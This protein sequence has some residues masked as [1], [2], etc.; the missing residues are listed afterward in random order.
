MTALPALPAA[1][2]LLA[3]AAGC[4]GGGRPD[5]PDDMPGSTLRGDAVVGR[6]P[7]APF[8]WEVEVPRVREAL[9]AQPGGVWTIDYEAHVDL[10][11]WDERYGRFEGLVLA[12]IAEWRHDERGWYRPGAVSFAVASNFS[13][14]GLPVERWDGW[15]RSTALHGKE[16][17]PFEG[18]VELPLPDDPEALPAE[19]HFE[20][21]L[22]VQ[23]PADTPEGWYEPRVF[24]LA[25][26]EGVP[27]PVH[28]GEYS[29]E[30][31]DWAPAILPLVRVGDPAAPR[32]PWSIFAE[33]PTGGRSGTLPRQADGHV[34]LVGRSGFSSGLIL[35]PGRYDLA[36]TMPT[37]FPADG[38][39]Y[40]D[41][42]SDVVPEQM[43]HFM[44]LGR[45][46]ATAAVVGPDGAQVDLGTRPFAHP[47][48]GGGGA[49]DR[50][51]ADDL[52]PHLEGSEQRP[53]AYRTEENP[54]FPRPRLQGGPWT[55]DLGATGDY[56]VELAGTMWDR[57]GREFQAGGTYDVTVARPLSF[58]SSCKP[59]HS[60][61]VGDRYSG[62]IN[63]NPP[64]PAEVEVTIDWYPDSDPARRRRWHARGTANRFGHYYPYDVPP[65]QFEEPGEYLS[66]VEVT[67]V[68]GRGNLWKGRQTSGGV[69]AP[70]EQGDL[71]IHGTRSFPFLQWT[72]EGATKR[73]ADRGN[74]LNSFLPQ[75]NLIQQ[76]PFAPYEPGDTL[77]MPVSFSEENPVNPK[78]SFAVKDDALARELT[79]ACS[80]RS[81]APIPWNQ[82]PGPKWNYLRDVVDL[83]TDS[84]AYFPTSSGITDELPIASV[85]DEAGWNP[86]GFPQRR[87]FEAYAY[88]G[89]LR[90][91]FPVLTSV[92]E[93]TPK[94]FYWNASPNVFGHQFNRGLNGDVEGDVYRLTAGMVLKDLRTGRNR[95]D[96]YAS[97]VAV[98]NFDEAP[99]SV[100]ILGPGERPL[101]AANGRDQHIF[102]AADTHD[103]L[104][105]GEVMGLGGIVMPVVEADVDWTVTKPSGEVAHMRGRANRLGAVAGS[106]P[107]PVDE[108]G[109]YRIE[110]RVSWGELSGDL[111]GLVDGSYWHAAVPA[112]NPDEGALRAA[113]PGTVVVDA[114]EGL[115]I[116]LGW[117]ADLE[118]VELWFGVIMPGQVLDQGVVEPTEPAFIYD[119]QPIQWAAQTT[120]FDARD[121]GTGRWQLAETVVFQ[122]FLKAERGGAPVYDALRLFL[123]R[124]R[125]YNDRALRR[126]PEPGSAEPR[127]LDP[128]SANR[129]N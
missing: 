35:P 20:G 39:A 125:L 53:R 100:S 19:H 109:I 52:L 119:F 42:G 55:V 10:R 67:Y 87:R 115:A 57:F 92:Y 62:K 28:L 65:L 90:P 31:N 30:W 11:A 99:V 24:V 96:A 2:A 89:I 46:R 50:D 60:F 18:V 112:D 4:A 127:D 129:Y 91:G 5:G 66:T 48:P 120:N 17:S 74:V 105:V 80:R 3:L 77:F 45:G 37:L 58:S 49:V 27:D 95:Y 128:P 32:L 15:P 8:P 76:D 103:A 40:V 9:A 106:P 59:G 78:F 68:D 122:F 26:V 64:F 41:G 108:P 79:A 12:V 114:A 51:P 71:A 43:G 56:R 33:Y 34:A 82:P 84:F 25:R 61:L 88:S 70:R 111:P 63:V 23:L 16:G 102:L 54:A 97:T 85:G 47:A 126:P 81:V 21:R 14:T 101:R 116:P 93:I 118:H 1:L 29:Y 69:V 75:T 44:D 13:T 73:F 124:D 83:S 113:L 121:A 38:M 117:D 22:T 98:R 72:T 6:W 94:G 7:G 107:L 36:P 86:Y 104:E 123:R 110:P